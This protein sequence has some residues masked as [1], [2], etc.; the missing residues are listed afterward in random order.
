[1]ADIQQAAI[2]IDV[3]ASGGETEL[4]LKIFAMAAALEATPSM[5]YDCAKYCNPWAASR[6]TPESRAICESWERRGSVQTQ[7]KRHFAQA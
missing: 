1:M 7:P 3:L 4:D 5:R 2:S 6:K